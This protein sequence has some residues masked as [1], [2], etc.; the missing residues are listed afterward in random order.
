VKSTKT[1]LWNKAVR[2]PRLP[3][4]KAFTP[5]MCNHWLN[6][7]PLCLTKACSHPQMSRLV[8]TAA[9]TLTYYVTC[10]MWHDMHLQ[11]QTRFFLSEFVFAWVNTLTM[12]DCQVSIG[13]NIDTLTRIIPAASAHK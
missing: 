12:T 11:H 1:T 4:A 5:P 6:I 7:N 2:V 13:R 8:T 10:D 9:H 3:S